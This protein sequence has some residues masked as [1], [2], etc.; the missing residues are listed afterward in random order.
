VDLDISNPRQKTR[1]RNRNRLKQKAG[2]RRHSG[3]PGLT[4][5]PLDMTVIHGSPITG[6]NN[7]AQAT[8]RD[9]PVMCPICRRGVQ[10]RMRSQRYCSRRCRDRG[11][12]RSRKAFLGANT[13][14][15]ATPHKSESKNNGLQ[16]SKN[17]SSL[18]ANAPLNILGG[19]SWRW[20]APHIDNQTWSKIVRAEICAVVVPS[21]DGAAT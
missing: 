4:R 18:F 20:P 12:K 11:R 13:G 6:K 7:S 1:I 10:R 5:R 9:A 14:A 21:N 8:R 3:K 19:G 17:G 15:P 16:P 2:P